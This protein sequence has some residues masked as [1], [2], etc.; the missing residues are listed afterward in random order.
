MNENKIETA[1]DGI[2]VRGEILHRSS[3]DFDIKITSPFKNL[4]GGSHIPYFAVS[5]HTFN[6]EYGDKA[7]TDTLQFLYDLGKYLESHSGNF[8]KALRHL[9]HDIEK[10]SAELI[11]EQEF[12]K[13]RTI[14]R[15]IM[16]N[17][18]IDNKVYQNILGAAS[19]EREELN[20]RISSLKHS[21]FDDNFPM[22]IPVAS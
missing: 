5:H 21:F 16:S 3:R 20:S 9:R 7:I 8:K 6:G 19:K 15:K 18:G 4:T 14:L 11:T 17:G 13:I 1:V 12:R 10:V 22:T 2:N